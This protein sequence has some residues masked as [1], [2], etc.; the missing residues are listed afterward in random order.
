MVEACFA[1]CKYNNGT[2]ETP[3]PACLPDT[4]STCRHAFHFLRSRSL[5]HLLLIL[6]ICILAEPKRIPFDLAVK[7]HMHVQHNLDL[8]QKRS[9]T[10]SA[11]VLQ[12]T[13]N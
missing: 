2:A 11:Q 9:Q 13:K 4:L 7:A 5:L 10:I 12:N 8:N 1:C 6:L 3:P